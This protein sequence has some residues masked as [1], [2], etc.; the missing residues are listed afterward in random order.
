MHEVTSSSRSPT[1]RISSDKP[2]Y[3]TKNPARRPGLPAT[4]SDPNDMDAVDSSR[5][6]VPTPG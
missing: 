4:R 3:G 6:T 2:V 1:N 5:K